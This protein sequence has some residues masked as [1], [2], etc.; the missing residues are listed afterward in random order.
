MYRNFL[1]VCVG[2]ALAANV[3]LAQTSARAQQARI[4]D[5]MHATVSRALGKEATAPLAADR[6]LADQA[7]TRIFEQ[8]GAMRPEAEQLAAWSWFWLRLGP[9]AVPISQP[10]DLAKIQSKSSALGKVIIRSQPSDA[11]ISVD[12]VS[13][14]DL[15]TN[16]DVFADAGQRT[17]RV[18]KEGYAPAEQPCSVKA[19]ATVTFSAMM[20][21][22]E[23]PAECGPY[24]P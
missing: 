22:K 17:V 21:A 15:L 2:I 8:Y 9:Q 23:S 11:A 13:L 10:L 7:A 16:T 5:S 14:G 18:E 3:T 19:K 6:T 24:R 1:L 12:G 20:G 4:L